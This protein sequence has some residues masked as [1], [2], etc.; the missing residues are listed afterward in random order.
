MYNNFKN[1]SKYFLSDDV[2]LCNTPFL[3]IQMVRKGTFFAN[4]SKLISGS[5]NCLITESCEEEDLIT[6]F[7]NDDYLF[8]SNASK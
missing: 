3:K 4:G 7:L 6:S 5:L 8:S 1:K 2:L